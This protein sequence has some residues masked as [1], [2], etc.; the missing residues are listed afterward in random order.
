LVNTN[1]ILKCTPKILDW[2]RL[3]DRYGVDIPKKHPNIKP[4]SDFK[5]QVVREIL[6]KGLPL[7]HALIK[8]SISRTALEGGVR[9]VRKHGYTELH[10][11]RRKGRPSK[12]MARPK[13]N[14]IHFPRV[15]RTL[16]L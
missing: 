3:Y 15:Q 14:Q 10:V 16:W 8:Y 2:V 7:Y 13:K 5:E 6:E 9:T 11:F 1:R 4:T 12:T